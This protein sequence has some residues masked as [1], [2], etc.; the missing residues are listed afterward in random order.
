VVVDPA[1]DFGVGV[2]GEPAS[3]NTEAAGVR[4]SRRRTFVLRFAKAATK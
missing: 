3:Q 4:G 1:Q 2:V